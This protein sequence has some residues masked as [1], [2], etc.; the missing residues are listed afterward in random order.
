MALGPLAGGFLWDATGD[1]D[2]VVILS[3]ALSLVGLV[4]VLL[5]P[6]TS[7]ELTPDWEQSLPL[8]LRSSA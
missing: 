5:L 4:S 1:F 3:A 7:R 8:A 6:S 2:S